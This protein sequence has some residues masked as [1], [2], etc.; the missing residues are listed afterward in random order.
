MR[1]DSGGTP[2][3]NRTPFGV[4]FCLIV[5]AADVGSQ[6]G[7]LLHQPFVTPLHEVDVLHHGGALGCQAGDNQGCPCPQIVGALTVAVLPVMRMLAPM[8]CSSVQ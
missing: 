1:I 2:Q 7:E 5:D 3:K 4:L 8:D 6:S